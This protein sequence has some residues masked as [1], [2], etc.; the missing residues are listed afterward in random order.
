MMSLSTGS[1]LTYPAFVF[2]TK[3]GCGLCT[4]LAHKLQGI[5]GLW[6]QIESRDITTQQ[7]WWDRYSLEVPVLCV[8]QAGR[9]IPLPRT[10][11]RASMEQVQRTIERFLADLGS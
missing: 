6:P 2:Y 1:D 11:P 8:V 7:D 3:E 4:E 5:P 10:S 9:E